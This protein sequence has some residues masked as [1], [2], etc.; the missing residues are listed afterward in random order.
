LWT[1]PGGKG[2][3]GRPKSRWTDGLEEDTRQLGCR[4]RRADAQDRGRWR[5]LLEEAK[6]CLGLYSHDDDDYDDDDHKRW[7]VR[8]IHATDTTRDSKCNC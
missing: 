6:A 3:R 1:N 7:R 4:N 5:H 8:N 2:G